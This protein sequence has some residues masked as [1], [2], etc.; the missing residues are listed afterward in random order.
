LIFAALNR[1]LDIIVE[2][3]GI[4]GVSDT[5]SPSNVRVTE[6]RGNLDDVTTLGN[7]SNASI[8]QSNEIIDFSQ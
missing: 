7:A 4:W 3:K 1:R 2:Y 8:D 5:A 6:L